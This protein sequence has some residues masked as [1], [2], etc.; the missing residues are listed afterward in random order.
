[1]PILQSLH[2]RTDVGAG[3]IRT[4][5]VVPTGLLSTLV[6]P[7]DKQPFVPGHSLLIQ[8]MM[9]IAFVTKGLGRN[10]FGFVKTEQSRNATWESISTTIKRE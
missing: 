10:K 3:W 8:R 4:G 2:P 9:M 1:M 7:V 6:V 5:R